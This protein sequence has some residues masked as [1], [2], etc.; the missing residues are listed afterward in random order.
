MK[1]QG[2]DVDETITIV[3]EHLR[4]DDNISSGLRSAIELLLVL[5]AVLVN[6]ITL[7]SKNSSKPPSSDPNRKKNKKKKKSDRKPVGQNGHNGSTLKRVDDPDE[8]VDLKIA[9]ETLPKDRQFHEVGVEIRQVIDIEINQ[10]VTEYRAQILE[11]ELGNKFV[12]KFP[13]GVIRPVQYGSNVRANAV[14]MSYYQMVPYARIKDHFKDQL[15]L[16]LSAGTLF[17]FNKQ[18]YNLLE[19]FE[20]WA[21]K[22]IIDSELVHADETGINIASRNRWLHCAS[23]SL[24]TLF[25]PHEKRGKEAMDAMGVL[26]L[27]TGILCHD[28]WKP[29]FQYTCEHALCNAHHLRELERAHD[30]D[31]QQWAFEMKQFLLDANS[32]VLDAGG[33]LDDSSCIERQER[34]RAILDQGDIECPP[35]KEERKDGKRGRIKRSK[36]RNLLERLRKFENETLRFMSSSVTPFTNNQGEND[37]RMTKVHQK[38]SGCF[39]SF[40][41]AEIFCRVRSFIATARKHGVSPTTAL[42]LLFQGKM[43]DFMIDSS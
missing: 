30:Q 20:S 5:L 6:T 40:E 13:F 27:F 34:Y 17:N 28:H 35:P 7:N 26:P 3:K 38:V 1:V 12:A 18:A 31:N 32:T 16:P 24:I 9:P 39:R 41:G 4:K 2:I 25:Y 22:Q 14:Y 33:L 19:S 37:I 11:D 8:V 10:I 15:A 23:T 21:K 43:P 42:R 36:S 29:Y